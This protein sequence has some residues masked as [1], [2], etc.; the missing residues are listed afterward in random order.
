[1]L[2][3]GK[4]TQEKKITVSFSYEHAHEDPKLKKKIF[5]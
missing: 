5:F 4:I 2:K 1:M 3:P